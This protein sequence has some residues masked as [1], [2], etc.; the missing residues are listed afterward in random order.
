MEKLADIELHSPQDHSVF[1]EDHTPS[2]P[3][4]LFFGQEWSLWQLD[5]LVFAFV[6]MLATD[7][8]LAAVV[9]F[10]LSG[11]SHTI[12]THTHSLTSSLQCLLLLRDVFGRRN[13]A[14]KTLVDGRFLI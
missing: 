12:H 2:F 4:I 8:V 11:V 9:T 3:Q 7:Y 5:V 10:V 14:S 6:D 13:L 1:Y